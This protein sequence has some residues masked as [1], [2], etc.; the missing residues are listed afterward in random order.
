[1]DKYDE[2]ARELL[3]RLNDYRDPTMEGHGWRIA[4]AL[5]ES[6]AE[7]IKPWREAVQ[8]L[9]NSI[10]DCERV[11]DISKG[12]LRMLVSLRQLA[13]TILL[14]DAIKPTPRSG[15]EE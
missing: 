4:A 1:M 15:R 7:A 13:E 9:R 5:R 8:D 14:K 10:Q 12:E 2:K 6:A 11:E 3:A